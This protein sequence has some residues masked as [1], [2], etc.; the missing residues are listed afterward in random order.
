PSAARLPSPGPIPEWRPRTVRV[1]RRNSR[2][3]PSETRCVAARHVE[4]GPM[5]D[6]VLERLFLRYRE[7]GDGRALAAV[8]DLTAKELLAVA[9]HLSKGAGEA[10]DLVQIVFLRAMERAQSF[11]PA[12][13]LRPWLHGILWREALALRR[14]AARRVEPAELAQ[15]ASEDPAEVAEEREL[16]AAVRDALARLPQR[17]REVVEPLLLDEKPAHEIAAQLGRSSGTVRMQIHRG[18]ERLRRALPRGLSLSG[19]A[20]L[21]TRGWD[22]LRASVLRE[23]GVSPAS[24]GTLS[25]SV[26]ATQAALVAAPALWLVPLVAGGA[27]VVATHPRWSPL[28]TTPPPQVAAANDP[29]ENESMN[30]SSLLA[31]PLVLGTVSAPAQDNRVPVQME[32]V[33]TKVGRLDSLVSELIEISRRGD[34]DAK[35]AW[36][37]LMEARRRIEE[38]ARHRPSPT[39]SEEQA[40]VEPAQ[41][42]VDA[43]GQ[44]ADPGRREQAL[45]EIAAALSGS[46][47][48]QLA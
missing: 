38:E 17:Y 44:L 45:R 5:K 18:L 39:R 41:A 7:H 27:A 23:A 34:D 6:A 30:P 26:L 32:N 25:S 1:V 33:R 12:L 2:R 16:P 3:I 36:T 31:L 43:V 47:T 37:G 24:V 20:V 14:R 46:L 19:L 15:N 11:D 8:F 21:P 4:M 35:V 40:A 29:R 42:W 22:E 10:E 9:A 13:G 28:S 48:D